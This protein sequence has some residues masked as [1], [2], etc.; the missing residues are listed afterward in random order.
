M[1]PNMKIQTQFG[2]A[3]KL[4]RLSKNWSQEDL[5][6]AANLHRTYISG[7]ETGARNPTLTIVEKIAKALNITSHKLLEF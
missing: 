2:A 6:D 5:A 1:M 4:H 3:V 7:I